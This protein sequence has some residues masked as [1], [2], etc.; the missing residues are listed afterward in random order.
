MHTVEQK[1]GKSPWN[2]K[3]VPRVPFK[4][5]GGSRIHET[6]TRTSQTPQNQ[7]HPPT[8]A[9][10]HTRTPERTRRHKPPLTTHP[11]KRGGGDG[12]TDAWTHPDLVLLCVNRV[13]VNTTDATTVCERLPRCLF[14][15]T[16]EYLPVKRHRGEPGHTRDRHTNRTNRT[17]S[18]P[19][20]PPTRARRVFTGTGTS[21]GAHD[22]R[23]VFRRDGTLL[24]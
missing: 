6:D 20:H 5:T 13:N 17:P 8:H 9:P 10:D 21:T 11:I 24:D 14:T 19:T 3:R 7:P 18:K 16:C 1:V 15:G 22:H 12:H 2:N 23:A 4:N